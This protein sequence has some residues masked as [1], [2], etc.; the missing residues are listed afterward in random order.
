[1]GVVV[2]LGASSGEDGHVTEAPSGS[3][4]S[5]LF[6]FRGPFR[7]AGRCDFAGTVRLGHPLSLSPDD[8][9]Y[10]TGYRLQLQ[11]MWLVIDELN[12]RCGV[13]IQGD[14]YA[15]SLASA[16][17]ASDGELA[18]RV[19]REF[20]RQESVDFFLGPYDGSQRP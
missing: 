2:L 7:S 4:A 15:F 3:W 6:A 10:S 18:A 20:L 1:M 19:T 8:K 5:N 17:D 9:Y 11:A 13:E 14:R 12:D 16:D